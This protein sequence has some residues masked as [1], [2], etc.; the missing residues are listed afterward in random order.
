MGEFVD[1]VDVGELFIVVDM[2][3]FESFELWYIEGVVNVFFYFVDGFGGDWDWD[4]VGDFVCEG[5]V[6]VICGKGLF[7]MLFGFGLVECGYDDVEVVKGGMEDWS[8]LYE[9]V[10]FDIGDDDL[11][12]V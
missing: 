3:L 8:K 12:V 9:V 11:F 10:E 1:R 7:L 6:V 4:C 2:W 5:L